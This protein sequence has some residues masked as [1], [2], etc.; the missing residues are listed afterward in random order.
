MKEQLSREPIIF[1]TVTI[2]PSLKNVDDI[3][4]SHIKLEN[5]QAHASIKADL[6]V[7]GGMV[8]RDEE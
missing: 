7:V 6:A 4:F 5:Y 8:G 1:P 3:D 2:D